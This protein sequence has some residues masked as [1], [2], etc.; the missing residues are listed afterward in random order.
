MG[1][2]H[3][4]AWLIRIL[5]TECVCRVHLGNHMD[6]SPCRNTT[7]KTEETT[8]FPCECHD[9][10][11]IWSWRV[12]SGA[13]SA[14]SNASGRSVLMEQSETVIRSIKSANS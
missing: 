4:S 3:Q 8:F 2:L 12:T 14:L 5:C 9:S 6:I 13:S 7:Q 1:A 11:V 10:H